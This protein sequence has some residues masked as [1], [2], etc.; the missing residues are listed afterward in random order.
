MSFG[1][2]DEREEEKVEE[3][4]KPGM[5]TF[6][7]YNGNTVNLKSASGTMLNKAI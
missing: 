1:S 7:T 5:T 2:E 4:P 3:K 6:T